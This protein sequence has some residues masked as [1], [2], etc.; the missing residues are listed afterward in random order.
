MKISNS[1]ISPEQNRRNF[2]FTVTN[3]FYLFYST[4]KIVINRSKTVVNLNFLSYIISIIS[5]FNILNVYFIFIVQ[6]YRRI[7][8][9]L[10]QL[11]R[12]NQRFR[13]SAI[14]NYLF[15]YKIK[16]TS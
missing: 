11:I 2:Y 12:Q 8:C 9:K 3:F 1:K 13:D 15:L 7:L 6:I 5:I 4:I 14:V 16:H 10:K